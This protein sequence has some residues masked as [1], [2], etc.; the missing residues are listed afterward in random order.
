MNSNIKEYYYKVYS[1]I[2]EKSIFFQC[3]N[4][5]YYFLNPNLC[6]RIP[7]LP[8]FGDIRRYPQSRKEWKKTG[9]FS[10]YFDLPTIEHYSNL[11][12]GFQTLDR[13]SIYFFKNGA[14]IYFMQEYNE[15]C[16]FFDDKE[17]GRENGLTTLWELLFLT[18][19]QA[20]NFGFTLSKI[21]SDSY[22]RKI[23]FYQKVGFLGLYPLQGMAIIEPGLCWPNNEVY[24]ME[25]YK[26][27]NIVNAKSIDFVPFTWNFERLHEETRL[28]RELPLRICQLTHSTFD[29][30]LWIQSI[31][32]T[33][34]SHEILIHPFLRNNQCI[35]EIVILDWFLDYDNIYP[36]PDH[37]TF[38]LRYND[39]EQQSINCLINS[40]L[41]N[42]R[43][44]FI[45]DRNN[46]CYNYNADERS[47]INTLIS[48]LLKR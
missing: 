39:S 2:D 25:N 20:N 8:E 35:A 46:P 37:Y 15:K 21:S 22:Y 48:Y 12:I 41:Q 44:L 6:A 5:E 43:H 23:P 1:M 36:Y 28:L 27:N 16:G 11:E 42:H 32:S 47:L 33:N 9:R 38:I 10:H 3:E 24:N 7:E 29:Q 31:T 45:V 40:L 34:L 18:R 19:Q 13:E 30:R 17:K 4:G 26:L 14:V